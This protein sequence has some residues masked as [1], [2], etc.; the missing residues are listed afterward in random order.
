LSWCLI[1][2]LPYRIWQLY[3]GMLLTDAD[4]LIWIRDLLL[5]EIVLWTVNYALDLSQLPRLLRWD[6]EALS[7]TNK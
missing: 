3:E 5:I 7:S 6:L 1:Y 4:E 2:N